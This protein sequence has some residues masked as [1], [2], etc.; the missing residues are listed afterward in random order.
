MRL[1][2]LCYEVPDY[3]DRTRQI[4]DAKDLLEKMKKSH[5]EFYGDVRSI[6]I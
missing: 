6:G 4:Q 1:E 2:S 5:R 3:E